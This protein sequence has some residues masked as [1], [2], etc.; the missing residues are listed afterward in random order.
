MIT[1]GNFFSIN[2]FNSSLSYIRFLIDDKPKKICNKT[3]SSPS[4]KRTSSLPEIS[5]SEDDLISV[6]KDP[7]KRKFFKLFAK[8]EYSEENIAFWEEV[9]LFMK[10]ESASKRI[11]HAHRIIQTYFDE[12]SPHTIN[13]SKW[14]KNSVKVE[15]ELQQK[16]NICRK[17]LFHCV[18]SDL[19]LNVLSDTFKRFLESQL[20]KEMKEKSKKSAFTQSWSE[21]F[22]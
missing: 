1:Q 16:F 5:T 2:S 13:T 11:A 15:L 12:M 10:E 22:H 19:E 17:N 21:L 18:V 20:Y 6:L 3:R 4:L 7:K 8:K 14:L 9:Q